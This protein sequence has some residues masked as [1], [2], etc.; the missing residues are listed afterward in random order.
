MMLITKTLNFFNVLIS[1]QP[2]ILEKLK[3][4]SG[5]VVFFNFDSFVLKIRI[6]GDGL[7][8]NFEINSADVIISVKQTDI[9]LILLNF[10]KLPS[11]VKVTG[12][13][14]FAKVISEVFNDFKF[15]L[16]EQISNLTGEIFARKFVKSS[17]KL[18]LEK[19]RLKKK[20]FREYL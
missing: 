6:R 5:R 2:E 3:N 9:L 7:L 20:C 1:G 10:D 11:F 15:D 12:D 18:I 13:A 19:K 14:D 8:E 17:T 4:F 16:E